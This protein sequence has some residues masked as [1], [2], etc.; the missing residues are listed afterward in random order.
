MPRGRKPTPVLTAKNQ[1]VLEAI[2]HLRKQL[3]YPPSYQEIARHVGLKTPCGVARHIERLCEQ[4]WIAKAPELPRAII[5]LKH[6]E[7]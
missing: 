2:I 3:G 6:P 7:S 1:V 5:V 4:G